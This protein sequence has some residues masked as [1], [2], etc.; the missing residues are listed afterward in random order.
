MTSW[1]ITRSQHKNLRSS[2]SNISHFFLFNQTQPFFRM[3]Q[4]R[5][6]FRQLLMETKKI[7]DKSLQLASD[8]VRILSFI[9]KYSEY[10]NT[11]RVRYSNSQNQVEPKTVRFSNIF[12]LRMFL[13]LYAWYSDPQYRFLNLPEILSPIFNQ[14]SEQTSSWKKFGIEI[15][16]ISKAVNWHSGSRFTNLKTLL[17]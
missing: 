12:W 14:W 4:A 3:G 1:A 15:E 2:V 13:I 11:R 10:S 9:I 16:F 5:G 8:K 17:S 7:T 6:A